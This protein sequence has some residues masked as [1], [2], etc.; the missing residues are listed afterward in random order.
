VV[1]IKKTAAQKSALAALARKYGAPPT[2]EGRD[3]RS[4]ILHFSRPGES[5]ARLYRISPDGV[6]V[7]L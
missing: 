2:R 5:S 4:I 3:G 6:T 7:Q 1:E